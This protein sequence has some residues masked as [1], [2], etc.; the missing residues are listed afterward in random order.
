[1]RCARIDRDALV[2]LSKSLPEIGRGVDNPFSR[3]LAVNLMRINRADA[4]AS[5]D[6][7]EQSQT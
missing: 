7:S 5:K 4:L 6:N 1:M 3:S 2:Q